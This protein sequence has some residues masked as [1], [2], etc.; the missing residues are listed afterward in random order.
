MNKKN[1]KLKVMAAI[2]AVLVLIA[3]ALSIVSSNT[4]YALSNL[5]LVIIG[6]A[7]TAALDVIAV[8]L[9]DKLPG[10]IVDIMFFATAVLTAV[11]LCTMIQGRVLLMGYIYFSD[12]ESNNP[13]AIAA[14]NKAIISWVLY[15]I[16]L[17]INFVIGF[18]KHAKD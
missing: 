14:M 15:A 16:A 9:S 8:A 11:A 7:V 1:T 17:L 13:I 5:N 18:S 4:A 3:L 6:C 10:V 12:L 2:N